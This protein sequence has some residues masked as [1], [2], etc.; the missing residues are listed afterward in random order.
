MA[1]GKKNRD[2]NVF[3]TSAID[4]F[5]SSMGVFII[6]CA[7]LF[8]YFKNKSK[9][10]IAAV[11]PVIDPRELLAK[12]D[13][14]DLANKE[15]VQAKQQAEAELS[16]IKQ[17]QTDSSGQI[18]KY[19]EELKRSNDQVSK[20]QEQVTKHQEQVKAIE[21]QLKVTEQTV[22]K[23][24]QQLESLTTQTQKPQVPAAEHKVVVDQLAELQKALKTA[25]QE[26]QEREIQLK[27][28]KEVGAKS[29]FITV[30]VQWETARHDLDLT[31]VDPAG[32]EFSF[33]KKAHAGHPGKFTLDSKVGPGAEIWQATEVIAGVY[34]VK[35]NL[36]NDY[37]NK[38]ETQA[39]LS[40]FTAQ[41]EKSIP[42]ITIPITGSRSYQTSF[43]IDANNKIQLQN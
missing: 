42:K 7:L 30:F 34:K 10:V 20:H 22:T 5:A 23:L 14:L 31:L 25:Q 21:A 9:E 28:L 26:L 29:N 39:K 8:P 11:Q 43:S 35:L 6:I 41:G 12:I 32:K 27:K 4:L 37:G 2:I 19:E 1:R 18:K 38:Q 16:R 33:Q 17:F 15:A 40:I 36:Y 13:Q 3:S 24:R